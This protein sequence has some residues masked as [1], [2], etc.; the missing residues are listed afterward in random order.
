LF[1]ICKFVIFHRRETQEAEEEKRRTALAR[2]CQLEL[3][4]QQQIDSLTSEVRAILDTDWTEILRRHAENLDKTGK[5]Q[6]AAGGTNVHSEVKSK[7]VGEKQGGASEQD[8]LSCEQMR[9]SSCRAAAAA[10]I[11]PN[12]KLLVDHKDR[13]CEVRN[14][15]EREGERCQQTQEEKTGSSAQQGTG[16]GAPVSRLLLQGKTNFYL[17][18]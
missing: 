8:Q 13:S 2:V 5:T 11:G 16:P 10:A 4:Q 15:R 9:K 1:L 7:L 18:E 17:N 14:L 3:Q 12:G 6:D